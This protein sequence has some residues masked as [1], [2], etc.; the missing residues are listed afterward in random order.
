MWVFTYK[1]DQDGYLTSFKARLVVHRDLQEPPEDTYT[2]TLAIC[3]FRALIAI[4]NYFDLELKQYNVPTAF[5]NTKLNR[6]LYVRTS[7]GI[8]HLEHVELLEVLCALYGLKELP[9]L[10]YE[11]LKSTLIKLELKPVEGFPCFYT[12]STIILF[13]YVDDIIM[14]YYRSNYQE[15]RVLERQL[16]DAYDLKTIGDLA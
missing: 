11:E 14:A 7:D 15:H 9:L 12:N 1:I 5:L 10:W 8:Q 4:A 2:A 6:K 16:I 13:V 3:N